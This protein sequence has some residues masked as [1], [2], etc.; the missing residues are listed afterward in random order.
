[1]PPLRSVMSCSPSASART[2]TAHSLKAIGIREGVG[3]LRPTDA[4]TGDERLLGS[5]AGTRRTLQNRRPIPKYRHIAG[6][7]D[8]KVRLSDHKSDRIGG[9]TSGARRRSPPA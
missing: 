2:V 7:F 9:K 5:P 4:R 6:S 1:M 3:D 8:E